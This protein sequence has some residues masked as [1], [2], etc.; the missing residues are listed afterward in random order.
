MFSIYNKCFI[1]KDIELLGQSLK[2]VLIEPR[3]S[4]LIIGFYDVQKAAY[5]AR[6]IACGISGSCPTMFA[7]VKKQ[8][9][10]NAVAKAIQYKFK[11]F[12]LKSDSWISAMSDKG[13]YILEK[14]E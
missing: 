2:D 7:L 12:N 9:D 13:A 10:A 11:Q 5:A 3:K 6:A 14:K 4:K 8:D 1:Y